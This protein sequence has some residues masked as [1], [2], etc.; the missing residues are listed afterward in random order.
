M[1]AFEKAYMSHREWWE[2][3]LPGVLDIWDEE[4]L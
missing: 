1:K 4:E 2:K 3:N